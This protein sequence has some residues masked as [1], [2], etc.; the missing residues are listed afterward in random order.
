MY[1]NALMRSSPFFPNTHTLMASTFMRPLQAS[2]YSQNYSKADSR[3]HDP[4]FVDKVPDSK[5]P[6]PNHC[7]KI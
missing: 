7:P 2:I 6:R 3:N 5:I 4:H 1:F